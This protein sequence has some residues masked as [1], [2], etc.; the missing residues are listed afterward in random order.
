MKITIKNRFT[1][2]TIITGKYTS[3]KDCLVKNRGA[4]L[5]S[6]DLCGA[7]LMDSNLRGADLRVADLREADLRNADLM[8]ADLRNANLMDSNLRGAN[9]RGAD[10]READLMD[11]NLRVADLRNADLRNANL[12]VAD[13]RN[14]NL[15]DSNLR[16]ANLRGAKNYTESH[17]FINEIVSREKIDTFTTSEWSIMGQIYCHN[18]CWDSIK[19]RFGKKI[20]PIFKKLAK[21]GFD[22]YLNKIKED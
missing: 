13:L 2:E 6:A 3:I 10:L 17:D 8:V 5:G 20:I 1:K 15:M 12:M 21:S 16:G 9:L 4:Y 22:E 11:S 18:L 7:D 19:K 14:A